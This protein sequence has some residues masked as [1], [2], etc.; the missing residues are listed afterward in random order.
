MV[1]GFHIYLIIVQHIFFSQLFLL[2]FHLL[3]VQTPTNP[4]SR[5]AEPHK[6]VVRTVH[7]GHWDHGNHQLLPPSP[8][9]TK[10]TLCPWLPDT[11]CL[12]DSAVNCL[13]LVIFTDSQ[14]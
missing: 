4:L 10:L 12:P 1:H 9:C 8:V 6:V 14:Q 7:G 5:G 11:I 13:Q 2:T 3:L